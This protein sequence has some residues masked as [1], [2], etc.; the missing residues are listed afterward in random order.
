M[1][2]WTVEIGSE[3]I[4]ITLPEDGGIAII[5]G[6]SLDYSHSWLDDSGRALLLILEGRSYDFSLVNQDGDILITHEGAQYH[7]KIFDEVRTSPAS[8][9]RQS[10]LSVGRTPIKSPMPGLVV[11][12]LVAPGAA[13][14]KGDRLIV[15]EAMKMENDVRSPRDGAVAS[16]AVSPGQAVEAG[17]ELMLIE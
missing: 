1:K 8:K 6:R 9:A 10:E 16:V 3:R 11:K 13:V 2:T 4:E 14:R 12:V 15:L 5:D 7:C 17:R